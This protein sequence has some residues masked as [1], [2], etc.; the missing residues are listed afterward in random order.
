[1]WLTCVVLALSLK[2]ACV[3]LCLGERGVQEQPSFHLLPG[4]CLVLCHPRVFKVL[5]VLLS[6]FHTHLS[7]MLLALYPFA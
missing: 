3:S 4:Q 1:M 7:V 2:L 6:H 5:C